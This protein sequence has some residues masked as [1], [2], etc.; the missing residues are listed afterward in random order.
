MATVTP[1]YPPL[2]RDSGIVLIEVRVDT[3]GG[4]ADAKVIRSA[5]PF[6]KPALD[7]ARRWTFRPAR[8][9]GTSVVTLAYIA[10]AFRQPVTV[11]PRSGS[12]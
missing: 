6:D 9:R 11:I 1:R 3:G 7:A 12:E 4:V 2:A 10:F 8:V 5:R